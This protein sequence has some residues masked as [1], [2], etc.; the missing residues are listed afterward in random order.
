M[1]SEIRDEY[2][3]YE[4]SL[5]Q[6]GNDQFCCV[7]HIEDVEG[8]YSHLRER[9]LKEMSKLNGQ[10]QPTVMGKLSR[11]RGCDDV[12]DLIFTIFSNEHGEDRTPHEVLDTLFQLR[13]E[14]ERQDAGGMYYDRRH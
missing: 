5:G 4:C 9:F 2:Q 10:P 11:N 6:I 12:L 14:A 13:Q 7:L 8:Y 1:L 3:L